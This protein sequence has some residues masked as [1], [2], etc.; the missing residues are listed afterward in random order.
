MENDIKKAFEKK[1]TLIK[2]LSAK[3]ESSIEVAN[4]LN[5]AMLFW[6]VVKNNKL[7]WEEEIDLVWYLFKIF[8]ELKTAPTTLEMK[9]II[10]IVAKN[11]PEKLK[12]YSEE[13]PF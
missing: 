8:R 13:L 7:N 6:S 12:E 10:E 11:E 9:R 4:S 2:D 5:N 3:K 1:Q